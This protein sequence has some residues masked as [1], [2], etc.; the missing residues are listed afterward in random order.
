MRGVAEVMYGRL[1]EGE[2]SRR[3]AWCVVSWRECVLTQSKLN[4]KSDQKISLGL[5]RLKLLRVGYVT[6]QKFLER[7]LPTGDCEKPNI[8][9]VLKTTFSNIQNHDIVKITT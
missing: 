4:G 8:E 2:A 6:P 5:S 9:L 7:V 1:F 3:G